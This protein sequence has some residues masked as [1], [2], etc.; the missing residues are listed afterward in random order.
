[1]LLPYVPWVFQNVTFEFTFL[2]QVVTP[3]VCCHMGC[4]ILDNYNNDMIN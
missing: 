4:R 2:I 1:M 3:R